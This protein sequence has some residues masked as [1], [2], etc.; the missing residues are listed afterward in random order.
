MRGI[1]SPRSGLVSDRRTVIVTGANGWLG[2]ALMARLASLSEAD[3]N[4][5]TV[6]VARDLTEARALQSFISSISMPRVSLRFADLAASIEHDD[7]FDDLSGTVEVVHTAG[8]IHPRMFADFELVNAEGTRRLAAAARRASV[9]CFVHVSSNSPFGVNALT[10]DRFRQIE[11]YDPYLGYGRS[12]MH[13]EIAVLDEVQ[14]GLFALIVRPP[15]FY[16][17][18]Q[19]ARQTTFF[20]MVKAGRFPIFGDGEQKRSMVYVENLV[21]GIMASLEWKGDPGQGWWVA[22]RQPYSVNDIVGIVG[23]A[24]TDEGH[25]VRPP[26][27]KLPDFIGDFAEVADRALQRSGRYV[28]QLHVLGEMNKTIAC[29]ISAT[30]RDLG[31]VPRVDLY[32]G[33]R[34]SIRW[35]AENGIAL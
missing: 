18:H 15:W 33:M 9:R 23:R 11:P 6:A 16:G 2:R 32:E 17:P 10:S 31:Y 22:D 28:Q 30:T 20:S 27:L 5:H 14:R 3:T 29:D 13:G 26:R 8:V 34:R 35:C 24:L 12:K 7:L 4:L 25:E 21:D 19:P 1:S